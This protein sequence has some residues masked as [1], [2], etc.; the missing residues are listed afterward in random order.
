MGTRKRGR[1]FRA[2][3]RAVLGLGMSLVAFIIER[4]L[5]KAIKKGA[6]EPA[7]RVAVDPESGGSVHLAAPPRVPTPPRPPFGRASG[8]GEPDPRR[9]P[10]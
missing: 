6:V 5:I 10:G 3:E 9:A 1:V 7:P 2:F 8:A 4:R